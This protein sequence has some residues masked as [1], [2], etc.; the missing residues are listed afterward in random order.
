[1]AIEITASSCRSRRE[2]GLREYREILSSQLCARATFAAQ[3]EM[4]E[5]RSGKRRRRKRKERRVA[6][7]RKKRVRKSK[8]EIA[9]K[10]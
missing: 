7:R 3:S 9:G 10:R 2:T 8:G 4:M 1:M 5:E 6:K